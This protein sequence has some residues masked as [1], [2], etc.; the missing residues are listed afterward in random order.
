M[1]HKHLECEKLFHAAPIYMGI[2]YFLAKDATVSRNMF[3]R[4]TCSMFIQSCQDV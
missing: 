4:H 1:A 3:I 2:E